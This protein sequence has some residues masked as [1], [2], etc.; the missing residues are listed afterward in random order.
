MLV[1]LFTTN[2]EIPEFPRLVGRQGCASSGMTILV[3]GLV[4]PEN[5]VIYKLFSGN[6][7]H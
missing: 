5:A 2:E 3:K 1:L 7:K 6:K 4:I